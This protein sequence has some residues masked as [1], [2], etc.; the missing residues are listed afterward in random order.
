[1]TTQSRWVPPKI[2]SDTPSAARVYDYYLG[3]ANNF[4]VD[5]EL[6]ERVQA[7]LPDIRHMARANRAWLMRVVRWCATQGVDQFLDLGC[8]LPTAGSVHEIARAINRQARVMYV[9]NEPVAVAHGE[10]LLRDVPGVE[11]IQADLRYPWTY[12]DHQV[13]RELLDFRRPVAVLLSAV[14]HFVA[15]VDNPA[16]I[17]A[18]IRDGLVP[19][20]LVA[21]SHATGDGDDD[22]IEGARQVYERSQN[23]GVARSKV[24]VA[25]L[26]RG[27]DLVAPGVVWVPD[28]HPEPLTDRSYPP[29]RSHM[30]GVVARV[31]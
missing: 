8:G 23:P 9:D 24:E 30:Y 1:M 5:R 21:V 29:P 27:L 28:W 4:R 18:G 19:G 11:V 14:L 2:D 3:G 17:V 15:E 12:L 10:L 31:R 22:S 20:S 16:G 6:A 13:T 26:M 25:G 7:A